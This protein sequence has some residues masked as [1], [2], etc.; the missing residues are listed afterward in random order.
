M[1]VAD[2]LYY[3][4]Y[5]QGIVADP[6]PTY[7]RLR[8]EAPLYY[9]GRYD[10][11]AL[12]RHADVEKA[13][14][15]WSTFSNSRSD[16]LELIKSDFDMPKGVM[17]FEDPPEHTML[18]GLMSRVFTPRRMA[19]IEDQ[20]RR[21]CVNCLDPLVGSDGFDVIAELAAM[22]PMRVIGML[23]GIPE[24]EQ[25]SVRD[26]NDANL[27][28]RPGAP[29]KVADPDRIADGRIYSDYVEWR[30]ANPS[31]DLMTALLNV[32]FTDEAGV[33]RKLTR[34][35]V[36]H[37]TQVVA[38]AGNETTGR[39]I[40][41]LAKVLAEHPQQRR[42]I[43]EDRSL[44]GRAVD[45][46]LRF[47]PTGPHVARYLARDFEYDG[48]TVPA[49][50]AILLLFGAANRDERRY[51]NPDTFDI[52]RDNISHLTFGKGLHYC[53]GANLARLEGRVAL[54]ELLNRWPEWNIDYDTARL[55]PTS[56]VRGWEHLRML[57]G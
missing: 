11:W 35:E 57:V 36:L 13:L 52:H 21:Y 22:M 20:I 28:T 49:G 8:D 25:V 51:R 38:G 40:G 42:E 46:T 23:L 19:E 2:D 17:M 43:V 56:T 33:H 6:Y 47:E 24:S 45:E 54:D 39:L 31:D 27:R 44:L 37:Y 9:N 12:S 7:A 3:D 30:A 34:K 1:S 10:F 50:S 14:Q 15:D 55:A 4:P 5:D 41:W 26:A 18:R 16:I 48:T 29:M 32:E 53:L